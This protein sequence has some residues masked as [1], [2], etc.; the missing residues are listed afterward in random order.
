MRINNVSQEMSRRPV[1]VMTIITVVITSVLIFT[2]IVNSPIQGTFLG[3]FVWLFNIFQA[4]RA[5]M[6]D[7]P[8]VPW[9]VLIFFFSI[10]I[11]FFATIISRHKA[12]A[13]FKSGLNVKYINFLE[14]RIEFFFTQPQYNFSCSYTDIE[15]LHLDIESML[16]RTK[17]GSYITFKQMNLTFKVL[18]GKELKISNVTSSPM[19]TIYKIIDWT[20]GV[21]SFDCGFSGCGELPD[22]KE[23]IDN[24][25]IGG[26]RDIVGKDGETHLKWLSIVFFIIGLF[27]ILVCKEFLGSLVIYIGFGALIPFLF[28]MLISFVFDIIL[29]ID[30][31]RDNNFRRHN[32]QI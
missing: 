10:Y 25:L 7:D 24:Y 14:G 3:F 16:V 19:K 5:E 12:L 30:K 20:R 11:G 31:I 9:M 6:S 27:I 2:Y 28:V 17:N 4:F 26:Y 22:Y 15:N 32:G 8:F 29:V 21:Q 1:V 13:R 18:N 23:K